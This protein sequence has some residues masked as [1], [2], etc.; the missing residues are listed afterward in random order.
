MKLSVRDILK[1]SSGSLVSGDESARVES[2]STDSRTIKGGEMFFALRGVNHDGHDFAATAAKAGAEWVV[3]DERFAASEG[4]MALRAAG[5]GVIVVADTLTALGA[6]ARLSRKSSKAKVMA[7]TGSAGKTT[8]KDMTA[9]ILSRSRKTLKT[10]GNL[11]NLIGLPLTLFRLTE[12]DEAAVIELGISIPGEM[13]KLASICAPDVALVTNI[14]MSHLEGLKTREMV[15]EEK[16]KLFMSLKKGGVRVVN[17]DDDYIRAFVEKYGRARSDV[18]FAMRD[19]ADVVIKGYSRVN[20]TLLASYSVGG[21]HVEVKYPSPLVSNAQNG[22]AAMAASLCY[23]VSLSD[24][25]EALSTYVPAKGRMA[26]VKLVGVTLLDDTYNANPESMKAALK[27]M[28]SYSGRKIVISGDMLELGALSASLH[29]EVGS[30]MAESGV[31]EI[32]ATGSFASSVIDGALK[33]GMPSKNASV[34][35]GNAE[36]AAALLEM[37]SEGDVILVKGSR[38]M[39]ME[40]VVNK[41]KEKLS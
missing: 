7:I 19:G 21:E 10:E 31:N 16:L 6:A 14:G 40:E 12:D 35:S 24:M 15:A 2:F 20:G 33:A 22:A 4:A 26:V 13:E 17:M 38:G 18:T 28:S 32:I 8:T 23:G 5:S 25:A 39:R 37:V 11:N 36:A 30:F 41:L 27:T 29:E 9:A 3:V 1:A 34:V